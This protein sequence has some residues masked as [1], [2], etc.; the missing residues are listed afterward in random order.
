MADY[1]TMYP[2]EI[3]KIDIGTQTEALGFPNITSF[4]S[5]AISWVS[6]VTPKKL[7]QKVRLKHWVFPISNQMTISRVSNVHVNVM[8]MPQV[9]EAKGGEPADEIKNDY[10]NDKNRTAS[11][12]G[13][14]ESGVWS[15]SVDYRRD[16]A[17][18]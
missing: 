6:K 17:E 13:W 10:K 9:N 7:K 16:S 1:L 14:L 18:I 11:V 3:S 4:E 8:K 15:D 12:I 5:G 2:V